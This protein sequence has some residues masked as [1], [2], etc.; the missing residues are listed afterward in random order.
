MLFNRALLASVLANATVLALILGGTALIDLLRGATPF[1]PVLTVLGSLPGFIIGT[2]LLAFIFKKINWLRVSGLIL[3]TY[4]I[5]LCMGSLYQLSDQFH[6]PPPAMILNLTLIGI[7]FATYKLFRLYWVIGLAAIIYGL[8]L[9]TSSLFMIWSDQTSLTSAS[10]VFE[11]S[12][13]ALMICI[14][15][16]SMAAAYWTNDYDVK[17]KLTDNWR[18]I[19]II[20]LIAVSLWVYLSTEKIEDIYRQGDIS[21]AQMGE[22]LDSSL[23]YYQNA[24]LRMKNRIS[25]ESNIAAR[26]SSEVESARLWTDF[27][28]IDTV[29]LLQKG[30]LLWRTPSKS[31][32]KFSHL[33]NNT[34]R[35][36]VATLGSDISI[37]IDLETVAPKAVLGVRLIELTAPLNLLVHLN[38]QQL[39][40]TLPESY[41]DMFGKVIRIRRDTYISSGLSPYSMVS[42]DQLINDSSVV[43][44]GSHTL[45]TGDTVTIYAILTEPQM[46]L[47]SVRIHLSVL[48]SGFLFSVTLTFTFITNDRLRQQS[49]ELNT[50][51]T[52]DTVTS[53][54][55]RTFLSNQIQQHIDSRQP[56]GFLLFM[57]LDGFK[58]INDSLGIEIGNQVLKVIAERLLSLSD[59]QIW[60]SRFS[61]DEFI[62]FIEPHSNF[63]I[64]IYC[65]QTLEC[66][67]KKILL[68]DFSLYLTAS[69][70]V[71]KLDH[72][73]SRADEAI[74]RADI[75]MS[76]AKELGGNT[77][78]IYTEDM[79]RQYQ[80]T[81]TI[82]NELQDAL[83]EGKLE[84][85]YQPLV[86]A[87]SGFTESVEAL[88]RWPKP[89]GSYVSPAVFI[90]IAEQTGQIFQL[91]RFVLERAMR[92]IVELCRSHGIK[93]SVNLSLQ[94]FY[95]DDIIED[96]DA[97][98][99]ETG[100]AYNKLYFE[101][102]ESVFFEDT[103]LIIKRLNALRKKGIKIAIDDFG[104]GY[105][106]L[107]AI[108]RLPFDIIKVDKSF[109]SEIKDISQQS[110]LVDS[111]ISMAHALHKIIVV[112]GVETE[113]QKQYFA[114]KGC[115]IHQGFFYSKPLNIIDL[116]AFLNHQM[117]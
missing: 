116:K 71:Y 69:I 96:I 56:E 22:S 80:L 73:V 7:T 49:G 17:H 108:N 50:L 88:V 20:Q 32:E 44:Q 89:D 75:A 114:N 91:S 85:F 21:I 23:N 103:H 107:S 63:D 3:L 109:T 24:I 34:Y 82:R 5:L 72:E 113:S 65:D 13:F 8:V 9:G 93:L 4:S 74:Q 100:I 11:I 67:R 16:L 115:N 62:I 27:P 61:S 99:T 70:G 47:N 95:Q 12:V 84:V 77:Y 81:L 76:T 37:G 54:Y 111:V 87:D 43:I 41:F 53:L 68:D 86:N 45:P 64:V 79:S 52:R 39:L 25:D 105:S 102:T 104:T 90:P 15:A 19:L 6:P 35:D 83:D 51:A 26:M 66:V 30:E 94:Q 33:T 46:L 10:N 97:L 112:E 57:D 18:S 14:I 38:L 78:R 101:L 28:I 42:E 110:P 36:W 55:R 31:G 58:P 29:S 2:G 106:S 92:D 98:I 48:L 60:I 117:S 1:L 40:Q 59:E